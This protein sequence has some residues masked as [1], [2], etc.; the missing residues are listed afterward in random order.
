V[1]ALLQERWI[2]DIEEIGIDQRLHYT[3]LSDHSLN[4]YLNIPGQMCIQQ[5]RHE[6]P[7]INNDLSSVTVMTTASDK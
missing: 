7:E 1:N 2:M 5:I 4:D 6:F 3:S